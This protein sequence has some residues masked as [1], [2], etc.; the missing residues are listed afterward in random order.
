MAQKEPIKNFILHD[1]HG[2]EIDFS[3]LSVV[4]GVSVTFHAGVGEPYCESRYQGGILYLDFYNIKGKGITGITYYESQEDGGT[5]Y[6]HVT[7]DG[8]N[9]YDFPV[10]NGSR[11]NGITAIET[12]ESQED[13]GINTITIKTTDNQQGQQFHVKNGERGNGIASVTEELSDQDGQLNTYTIVD[14]DGREHVIHT[15][16]G[17]TGAQGDSV[18]V[19]QGDLPLAHVLGDDNTKAMSQKGVT[20]A[21]RDITELDKDE[22]D[23]SDDEAFPD[24]PY[25]QQ[26]GTYNDA[27]DNYAGCHFDNATSKG[28]RGK[29]IRLYPQNGTYVRVAF[30]ISEPVDG[31]AVVYS[32]SEYATSAITGD[33]DETLDVV[34]PDDTE[35]VWFQTKR[36]DDTPRPS[37]VEVY[38]TATVKDAIKHAD[39]LAAPIGGLQESVAEMQY[40]V[41]EVVD[42]DTLPKVGVYIKDN[43]TWKTSSSY[44]CFFYRVSQGQKYR[45]QANEENVAQYAFLTS[46][47]YANNTEPSWADEEGQVELQPGEKR[48]IEVPDGANYIYIRAMSGEDSRMP[49]KF[50]LIEES[51]VV[52]KSLYEDVVGLKERVLQD[53]DCSQWIADK[54]YASGGKWVVAN[55]N[56]SGYYFKAEAGWKGKNIRFIPRSGK[57][58]RYAFL[59]E[60]PITGKSCA[61]CEGYDG[62]VGNTGDEN[63]VFVSQI[64]NDCNWIWVQ[65]LRSASNILPSRV[66]VSSD[67]TDEVL[68]SDSD[69]I[70]NLV[71]QSLW[72]ADSVTNQPLALLHFSDIHGTD[73]AANK[74]KEWIEKLKSYTDDVL[75]TGDSADRTFDSNHGTQWWKDCGLAEKSLFVIGNHDGASESSDNPHDIEEDGLYW[76]GKGQQWDYDQYFAD[77]IEQWGVTMPEGYDDPESPYYKACYWHKDYPAQKVRLIG[78]DCMHRFDGIVNPETGVEDTTEENHEG[79]RHTTTEQE[80]WLVAR[81]NET[82]TANDDAYGY[83]VIVCCHYGLDDLTSG[84]NEKWVDADKRWVYNR[85]TSGGMVMSYKTSAIANFHFEGYQTIEYMKKFNLR[86]RVGTLNSYNKGNVNNFG[87][88]IKSWMERNGKFVCWLAGHSHRDFMY[89]PDMFP[90]MLNITIDQAGHLNAWH[91]GD[92]NG[93]TESSTCANFFVVDTQNGLLKIVRLGYTMN[94]YLNSH[95]YICYDYVNRKVISEG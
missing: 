63:H 25:P 6:I 86:N 16:N 56:Y 65:G 78:L 26:N 18:L 28:M 75:C 53:Y 20:D 42:I 29:H 92:R 31:A 77:Y 39:E 82:I 57:H 64:P 10:K 91:S 68:E 37:L 2:N 62:I 55:A 90:D 1:R 80:E 79:I 13:G 60:E 89:Y 61:F 87:E 71:R 3:S 17:R 41:I 12:E 32:S 38:G 30:F 54:P 22:Y 76:D 58:L 47:T 44:T 70:D 7:T 27:I 93:A 23:T 36:G 51:S 21:I 95:R 24:G 88:I 46:A 35:Y 15:R 11:G 74:I 69:D 66:V 94:K 49:A 14:T 83:S 34:V 73:I 40:F 8:G 72:V 33:T 45:I 9:E 43:Q 48:I 85:N 50:E 81:L 59:T 4:S 19:G 84:K 52:E 5:N 67:V